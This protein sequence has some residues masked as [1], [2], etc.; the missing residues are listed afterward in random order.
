MKKKRKIFL[1]FP[2]SS[3]GGAEMVHLDIAEALQEHDLSIFIRYKTNVWKGVKYART[4]KAL[5]EG[6]ALL[7][8]FSKYGN[9]KYVSDYLESNRFA[10][11]KTFCFKR[12]IISEINRDLNNIVLF[13]HRESIEFIWQEIN[14]E[15]K[16]I[17]I[18][19]NNSNNETPD[20]FY[21]NNDLAPRINQRILST[22]TMKELISKLYENSN[23]PNDFINRI[24]TIDHRVRIPS[25]RIL[26]DMSE[27]DI[28][29]VGRDVAQKRFGLVLELI[30]RIEQTDLPINFHIVGP[31]YSDYSHFESL[32]AKWYGE[33][34]NRTEIENLYTKCNVILLTSAFEGFPKAIAEGMAFSCVPIVSD[35]GGLKDHIKNKQNGFLTSSS[36]C[37]CVEESYEAIKKLLDFPDELKRLSENSY[38]YAK[39]NFSENR[40]NEAWQYVIF[41]N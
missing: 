7:N 22:S 35:V 1:F 17:D 33:I 5:E 13:W 9:V 2:L 36:D 24:E 38:Q 26:K 30:K 21:L 18:V 15:I 28:L 19:H 16:I 3:I 4:K 27:L 14:P 29:F 12:K 20:E 32:T 25:D 41:K 6:T 34:R 10:R 39:E 11:I 8:E 31:D 23:F 37:D 40:F